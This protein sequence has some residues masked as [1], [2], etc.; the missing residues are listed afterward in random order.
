M[1]SYST[2]NFLH[3]NRFVTTWIS[4]PVTRDN[5]KIG[6][7]DLYDL[8]Y[9]P[10]PTK[11]E[12]PDRLSF[13]STRACSYRVQQLKIDFTMF[14]RHWFSWTAKRALYHPF[15]QL[16]TITTVHSTGRYS[17][18]DCSIANASL[19]TIQTF[20]QN[21]SSNNDSDTPTR[22][23]SYTQ[24]KWNK[25]TAIGPI[26]F[27]KGRYKRQHANQ[28]RLFEQRF[29]PNSYPTNDW[30]KEQSNGWTNN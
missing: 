20:L 24:G 21:R 11:I 27:I 29:V 5:N 13:Q 6:P 14:N 12:I 1:S 30:M 26:Y 18:Y 15:G 7:K 9:K 8:L 2:F 10:P 23:H 19:G 22:L 28:R 17:W 16:F 25:N 3:T 4:P